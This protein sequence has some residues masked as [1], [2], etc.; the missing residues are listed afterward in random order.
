M[1]NVTEIEVYKEQAKRRSVLK[2]IFSASWLQTS[3][4]A[5]VTVSASISDT[6]LANLPHTY[7]KRT[8]K[9]TPLLI[10]LAT[11]LFNA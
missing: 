4:E 10:L 11:D 2:W 9:I 8:Y 3:S 1:E 7:I 6:R 5:Q